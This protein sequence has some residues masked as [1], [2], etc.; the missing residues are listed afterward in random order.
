MARFKDF[1]ASI[2]LSTGIKPKEDFPLIDAYDVVTED[3]TRL[4]EKLNSL[5]SGDSNIIIDDS[6]T[7]SGQ[8]ADAA[9]VRKLIDD[10]VGD[11]ESIVENI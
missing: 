1:L 3:G 4:S 7:Q 8:A 6:L 9:A 2:I 10:I 5:D 11:I